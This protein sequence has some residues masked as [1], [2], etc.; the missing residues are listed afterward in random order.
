LWKVTKTFFNRPQQQVPPLKSELGTWAKSSMDK[1]ELFAQHLSKVFKPNACTKSDFEH[2]VKSILV[3]DQQLSLPFKLVT[4]REL[5]KYVR[6]LGNKKTPGFDLIKGEILKQLP[7]K[8]IV[9]LT[10]L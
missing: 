9:F 3:S 1:A 4:P 7:K 6:S 8:P 5:W 2:E 10:M